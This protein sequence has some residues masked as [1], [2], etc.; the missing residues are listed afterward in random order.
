MEARDNRTVPPF[1]IA[2][3][4]SN[5][6]GELALAEKLIAVAAGC[7]ADAAKFQ[8]FNRVDIWH[9]PQTRPQ[10]TEL[11]KP[12]VLK[13]AAMCERAGVEFM[14]SVFNPADVGWL[15]PLVRRWKVASAEAGKQAL[16]RAV[17]ATGKPVLVS[18]GVSEA[19]AS[20]L[21]LVCV[22]AYPAREADYGLREWVGSRETWGI[23]DHTVGF[24]AAAAA[25]GMGAMV[26]EKH[27]ALH[28]QPPSPD[29]GPHALR[30]S[31]FAVFT[32]TIREAAA[33]TWGHHRR[34]ELPLARKRWLG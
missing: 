26:V 13:V 31:E 34:R 23:S 24:G 3:I 16:L 9:E 25:V 20:C 1:I 14:T 17:L 7:G 19:P 22:S 4:G 2:E 11:S 27:I 21:P 30:P 10:W 8:V 33:A 28:N 29:E 15:N 6:C 5:H 18:T 32:R 12:F